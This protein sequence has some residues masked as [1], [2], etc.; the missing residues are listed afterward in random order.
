MS[1]AESKSLREDC[2]SDTSTIV[3]LS[4]FVGISSRVVM[5]C[6]F[7]SFRDPAKYVLTMGQLAKL[8]IIVFEYEGSI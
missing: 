8:F 7:I 2:N 5:S 4:L 1:S 6:I 3:S